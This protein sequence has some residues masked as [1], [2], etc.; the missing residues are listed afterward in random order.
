MCQVGSLVSLKGTQKRIFEINECYIDSCSEN[1]SKKS[2]YFFKVEDHQFRSSLSGPS[3]V[4]S[5]YDL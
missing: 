4:I 1:A 5:G 3:K 2:V